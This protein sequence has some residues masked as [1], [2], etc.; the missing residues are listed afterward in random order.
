MQ[1][2]LQ[3]G[4]VGDNYVHSQ[5]RQRANRQRANPEGTGSKTLG[6]DGSNTPVPAGRP[7]RACFLRGLYPP[8]DG[9]TELVVGEIIQIFS[10]KKFQD[11]LQP[12]Q[13]T[14]NL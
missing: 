8:A 10:P 7:A 5:N 9:L 13:A 1:A 12:V 11:L 6:S 2:P 14:S 3:S 4:C